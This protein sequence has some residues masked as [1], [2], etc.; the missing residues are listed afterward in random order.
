VELTRLFGSDSDVLY[1]TN[2]Q[3]LLLANIMGAL[4]TS[5]V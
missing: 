3:L 2:F 4:G 1:E 5:L